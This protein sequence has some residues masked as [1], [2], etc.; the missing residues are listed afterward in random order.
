MKQEDYIRELSLSNPNVVFATN[1]GRIYDEFVPSLAH[2]DDLAAYHPREY[3]GQKAIKLVCSQHPVGTDEYVAD[4]KGW[5]KRQ[6]EYTAEWVEF[7]KSEK[8]PVKEIDLCSSVNQKVF[9]ALC[10]QGSIE[11][12]RIKWL[13]CKQIS[14][15][16]KLKN[17]KQLFI[18][19]AS[20]LEDITPVSLLDNLEVLIL[21]ET[22]KIDDYSALSSLKKLKVFSLCGYQSSLNTVVE[23]NDLDFISELPSL[24]YVDFIDV[25][26]KSHGLE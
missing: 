14:E 18:A 23:V 4:P 24:E 2:R 20:S 12:L 5:E 1:H 7:L 11:S 6:R 16:T 19:R 10:C 21:G 8:M 3:R 17:L 25:R 22:K 15:I 13:R 26:L 9:D